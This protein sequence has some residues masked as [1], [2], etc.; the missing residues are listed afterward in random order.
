MALVPA[1]ARPF[2]GRHLEALERKQFIRSLRTSKREFSFRHVLM[3]LSA[4]RSTTREDRARLHERYASWL[5]DEAPKRPP[6][7]DEILGYH[8]EQA[9]AERRALGMRGDHDTALA[10]QQAST[11][12]PPGCGQPGGTTSRR[13][14]TSCRGHT[15]CFQPPT[16]S[17]GR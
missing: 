10:R 13:P 7:L 9:V 6:E 15:R 2:I 12:P 8:L 14:Q 17:G 3:Q 1:Q 11:W 16:H 4:Y 5:W